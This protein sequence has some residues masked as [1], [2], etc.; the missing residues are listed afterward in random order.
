MCDAALDKLQQRI[1]MS[2]QSRIGQGVRFLHQLASDHPGKYWEVLDPQHGDHR[3][4]PQSQYLIHLTL[5][6]LW[7]SELARRVK[8]ANDFNAPAVDRDIS[9]NARYC[10]LDND[11]APFYLAKQ[12]NSDYFD[13]VALIGHYWALAGAMLRAKVLAGSLLQNWNR[14]L[15][16]LGMDKD[17]VQ[18]N[19][20][21]IYKTALAGTLF[22]RVG[23]LDNCASTAAKL[24]QLQGSDGGW[25]TDMRP[26]GS[27]DGVANVE[28]TCL[29]LICLD[30]SAK[31]GF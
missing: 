11:I 24:E 27:L 6:R 17:D 1:R 3:I 10:V 7:S 15:G 8:A 29:A 4:W 13:E 28:T 9:S 12:Q 19:L 30:C 23:M 2:T 31:G 5:K 14:S 20:Y 18:Y 16:V 21:R 25:V 22:A 26:D